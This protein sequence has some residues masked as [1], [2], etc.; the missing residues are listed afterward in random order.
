[1]EYVAPKLTAVELSLNSK[2]LLNLFHSIYK[3]PVERMEAMPGTL[4]MDFNL[5]DW[6]APGDLRKKFLLWSP[7]NGITEVDSSLHHL[8]LRAMLK[9]HNDPTVRGCMGV[10]VKKD[11]SVDFVISAISAIDRIQYTNVFQK[12]VEEFEKHIIH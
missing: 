4:P 6:G 9:K 1:M 11:K 2:R 7:I 12:E 3:M 10:F 5:I 8:D